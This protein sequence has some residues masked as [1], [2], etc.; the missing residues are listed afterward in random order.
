MLKP[1]LKDSLIY[2]LTD[3]LLK[4][5][6]FATFP[7]YANLF[8]V[9]E[10]GILS[11]AITL[12]SLLAVVANC[13]LNNAVQRHYMD[14]HVTKEKQ[15]K[16]VSTGLFC[17]LA[18]SLM[19]IGIS[20][21]FAYYYKEVIYKRE[22][23]SWGLIALAVMTILPTQIFQFSLDLIRLYFRPW[24]YTW[25][26]GSVNGLVIVLTPIFCLLFHWGIA[27]FLAGS[28]IAYLLVAPIAL[29]FIR[30]DLAWSFDF[31][32]GKQVIRYGYPF[33]FAGV[34]YWIFGSMDR[35]MLAEMANLNEVGIYSTAFKIGTAIIL[36]NT[37]FARA[38]SPY[39]LKIFREQGQ[40]RNIYSQAL[41]TWM[42]FLLVV[43]TGISLFSQELLMFLTPPDYW[44]AIS[45]VPFVCMGL[46][47]SGTTQITV[48][49]ISLE[50]KTLH[51]SIATWGT[52]LVNFAFNFLLIPKYGAKGAAIATLISYFFLTV[53][54]L[55]C[56]QKLHPIPLEYG[57]LFSCFVLAGISL[58]FTTWIISL[59]W[60]PQLVLIKAVFVMLIALVG[61]I[62]VYKPIKK[63]EQKNESITFTH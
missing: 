57:K 25:L 60:A 48:I 17:Q 40:Y 56:S 18:F 46:L 54:Y 59:N 32:I 62:S 6:S 26:N 61:L 63:I 53:Y 45:V 27:G 21:S 47:F 5:I 37:A 44:S 39:A 4:F 12:S 16:I 49:G 22:E 19:I 8:D 30:Q 13:G 50:K 51:L 28:L 15:Q 23:L 2:G 38:W 41:T 33:I 42:F 11:L 29:H 43:A 1:L 34:A 36:L 10:F 9:N 35:W 31:A 14:P 55:I 20:L 7:I 52:A 58:G 24:T 3:F